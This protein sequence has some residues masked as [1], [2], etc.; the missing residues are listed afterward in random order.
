[1]V[2]EVFA[3]YGRYWAESLRL[4]SWTT[5]EIL[6]GVTTFGWDHLEAALAGGKGVIV[7]T[8]HLGGWEWG[9]MYLI[10]NGHTGDGGGRAA[11]PAGPFRLVRPFPGDSGCRSCRSARGRRGPYC[12]L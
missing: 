11:A 6:A 12:R 1:M 7:A 5:A 3:N 2:A 8:P 10:A 9:A 4:P